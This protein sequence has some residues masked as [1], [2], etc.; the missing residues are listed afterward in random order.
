MTI[1]KHLFSPIQIGR[2]TAKNRLLMSAMSINFGVDENNY[3]TDQLTGY[4]A[5]RAK[6]GAGMILV[7]GGGVHPT[8][9]ELP[10]LPALWD[11]ACIPVHDPECP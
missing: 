8:G 3:V 10:G 2:M 4:L 1:L 9:L 7:G 5:A 11:D 6:G